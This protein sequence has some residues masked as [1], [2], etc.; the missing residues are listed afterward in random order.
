MQPELLP[1]ENVVDLILQDKNHPLHTE[2]LK[3]T[4]SCRDMWRSPAG[5]EWYLFWAAL[6]HPY[7]HAPMRDP[8]ESAHFHGRAEMA[9]L[10]I[11]Y[12]AVPEG[13]PVLT[14]IEPEP[15]K[16]NDRRTETEDGRRPCGSK[17]EKGKPASKPSRKPKGRSDSARNSN[18]RA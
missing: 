12:G 17:A 18:E 4:A 1:L 15:I 11:R 14:P 10:M 2:A 16:P 6:A 9:A 3:W 5:R 7:K 8:I 13:I